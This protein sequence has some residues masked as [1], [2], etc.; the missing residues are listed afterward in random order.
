MGSREFRGVKIECQAFARDGGGGSATIYRRFGAYPVRQVT[1]QDRLAF[2]K[3]TETIKVEGAKNAADAVAYAKW[4][5]DPAIPTKV[6][7]FAMISA[8]IISLAD[9]CPTWKPNYGKIAETAVWAGVDKSDIAPGGKYFELFVRMLAEMN[10]GTAQEKVET[11][12]E[13]AKK[14]DP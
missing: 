9:R 6:K 12:C 13:E 10:A 1:E 3:A 11:A 14:Y 5:L 4:W 2:A 8:R 7:T